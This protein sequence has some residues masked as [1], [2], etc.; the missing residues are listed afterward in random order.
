M[1]LPHFLALL[2]IVILAAALTLWLASAFGVSMAILALLALIG[3][4][5]V[6]LM[7]RVE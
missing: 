4:G 3:A 7:A 6:R 2:V 1:P 5:I